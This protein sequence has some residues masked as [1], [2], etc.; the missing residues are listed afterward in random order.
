M[1]VVE[2]PD[3]VFGV[4]QGGGQETLF[5]NFNIQK[6]DNEADFLLFFNN[7]LFLLVFSLFRKIFGW[8]RIFFVRATAPISAATAC[9]A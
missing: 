5:E 1:P 4:G 9:L 6:I 8:A 7:L 2:E 3:F